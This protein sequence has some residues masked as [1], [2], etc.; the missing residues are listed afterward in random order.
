MK[1]IITSILLS[2][3]CI[4]AFSQDR[5][6][7]LRL[8][9]PMGITYKKYFPAN[10]AIELGL[11]TLT[12]GWYDQYHENSFL[13]YKKYDDYNYLSHHVNSTVY[14]QGRYLFH[15][16]IHVEGMLGKWDWYWGVGGMLKFASIDYRYRLENGEVRRDTHTDI[17]LGPEGILGMEYT[18][19]DVPITF[20]GEFS[21]MMEFA[22][23]PLTFRVFTGLGA[24]YNF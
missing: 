10:K 23:R 16:D 7:G 21:L 22:D 24:R 6:I 18:L 14:F 3:C 19:E 13:D 4:A 5:G 2:T 11:G 20:F 9:A 8:G 1:K 15:N 17:D 12:P